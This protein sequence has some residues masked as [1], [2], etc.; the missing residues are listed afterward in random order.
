MNKTIKTWI[1]VQFEFPRFGHSSFVFRLGSNLRILHGVV[2]ILLLQWGQFP[3]GSLLR[4]HPWSMQ[5]RTS[6]KGY[7][8][9][10]SWHGI[11]RL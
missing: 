5:S 6:G 4:F 1:R 10:Y 9:K 3:H 8:L 2:K 11:H 7:T